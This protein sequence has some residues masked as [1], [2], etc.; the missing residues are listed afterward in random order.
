MKIEEFLQ[1]EAQ[2]L[3]KRE[4]IPGEVMSFRR[5]LRR[6][7]QQ[8]VDEL[9][10]KVKQHQL[11]AQA[12]PGDL[13]SVERFLLLALMETRKEIRRLKEVVDPENF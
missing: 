3:A 6:E 4:L 8:V 12:L 11:V 10:E 5:A 1:Y 9:L 7:D 13:I 2:R